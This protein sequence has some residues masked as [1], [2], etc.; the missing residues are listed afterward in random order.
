MIAPVQRVRLMQAPPLWQQPFLSMIPKIRRYARRAFVGLDP[1]ACEDAVEEVVANAAVA[2]AR[3]VQLDK[4]EIGYPT[5]LARYGVAQFHDGRRV[6]NRRRIGEVLSSYAQRR[7]GFAVERLDRFDRDEGEWKEAIVEDRRT[8]VPDQAAFRID[9][10]AWL[11]SLAQRQ[12]RI[13]QC[14]ALGNATSQV[15]LQFR[16]SPGRV[17]Q[18][19][20]ELCR[21]WQEFH[22]EMAAAAT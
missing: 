10:P 8:P 1:E 21:S 2:F 3:L 20:R 15:A 17:S 7:K 11:A 9:F 6:G 5:A 16:V 4:A 18:L 12:R 19:R 14:L 13:A 22:G